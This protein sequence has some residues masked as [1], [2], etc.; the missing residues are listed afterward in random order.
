MRWRKE[1]QK[2]AGQR[3]LAEQ[4]LPERHTGR[5]PPETEE[6]ASGHKGRTSQS[7]KEDLGE[8]A[9]GAALK[10]CIKAKSTLGRSRKSLKF[11]TLGRTFG[12]KKR[13]IEKCIFRRDDGE[14]FEVEKRA[15][16]IWGSSLP[17]TG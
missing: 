8:A 15:H 1:G 3:R 9:L 11:L 14:A 5:P 17:R 10:L 13:E 7:R 6:P 2:G 12:H 4:T 16:W